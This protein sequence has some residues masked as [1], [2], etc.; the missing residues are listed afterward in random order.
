MIEDLKKAGAQ[1]TAREQYHT[2]GEKETLYSISRQ[3]GCTV[4]QL[5]Q[6]NNLQDNAIKIGQ[7]LVV[8][9]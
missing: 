3:Y 7:Q 5:Q 9:K 2:V 4:S 6:W 8:K 1:T